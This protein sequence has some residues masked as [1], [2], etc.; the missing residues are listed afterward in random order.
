MNDNDL[1]KRKFKLK[2]KLTST[3]RVTGFTFGPFD[4]GR[5]SHA[6]IAGQVIYAG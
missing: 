6:K 1:Q 2:M 4:R 3:V 5:L